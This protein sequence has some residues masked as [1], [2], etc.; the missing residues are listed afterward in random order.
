LAEEEDGEILE[1]ITISSDHPTEENKEA[2]EGKTAIAQ[3]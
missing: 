1:N 3:T 2:S